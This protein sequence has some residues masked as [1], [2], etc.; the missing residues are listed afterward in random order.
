MALSR[1]LF[2]SH[3]NL[4]LV[5]VHIHSLNL[6]C[7]PIL[8]HRPAQF[9]SNLDDQVFFFDVTA[10]AAVP[11]HAFLPFL[12]VPHLVVLSSAR[13]R[14]A[15]VGASTLA[16]EDPAID[17][18]VIAASHDAILAL[19][20][21]PV[22]PR[23]RRIPHAL[24][25]DCGMVV[26]Q[27]VILLLSVLVGLVGQVIGWWLFHEVLAADVGFAE[28]DVA[29]GFK[30][31]LGAPERLDAL[32]VHR[33]CDLG[34][35]LA[36]HVAV[37]DFTDDRRILVRLQL[38]IDHIV[39]QD[40]VVSKAVLA[41]RKPLLVRPS[42]VLATAVALVLGDGADQEKLEIGR[43]VVGEEFIL[44]ED[45]HHVMRGQDARILL[46]LPDVPPE[47]ADALYWR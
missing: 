4:H 5:S 45:D 28:N 11:F 25:H 3:R 40:A 14:S 6:L 31:E 46:N 9:I 24:F 38:P 30:G 34:V 47:T 36:A 15:L 39:A 23:L 27:V 16:A 22:P 1:C 8:V 29:D 2:R 13:D 41:P 43:R 10:L 26:D 42:P 32:F 19:F 37:K 12:A 33:P 21:F 20:G 18:V 7:H 44:P 35:V 17:E